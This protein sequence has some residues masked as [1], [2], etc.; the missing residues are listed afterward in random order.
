MSE[1]RFRNVYLETIPGQHSIDSLQKTAILGTWHIIRK[2][3]QAET[4]SLSGGVHHW[5]KRRSTREGRKPVTR[6]NNNNNNDNNNNNN[7]VDVVMIC[8]VPNMSIFRPDYLLCYY[9][10]WHHV[11]CVCFFLFGE[12]TI[13]FNDI[14]PSCCKL[15]PTHW[16]P[17]TAQPN[18]TTLMWDRYLLCSPKGKRTHDTDRVI[19]YTS[20]YNT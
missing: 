1:K 2:V 8:F 17:H 10:V 15:Q 5:L 7:N 14:L 3:L 16:Q 12:H 11:S 9:T 19:Q 6:N 18:I 20:S 4:W 13:H